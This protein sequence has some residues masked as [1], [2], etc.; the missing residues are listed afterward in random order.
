MP[1]VRRTELPDEL[2]DSLDDGVE[3]DPGEARVL[4]KGTDDDEVGTGA[5]ALTI[6]D[7]FADAST[8]YRPVAVHD[9]GVRQ[10]RLVAM[11]ASAMHLTIQVGSRVDEPVAL[12]RPS[13]QGVSHSCR[14]KRR[15][16]PADAWRS[17]GRLAHPTR[18]RHVRSVPPATESSIG[19]HSHVR[20]ER[21][22]AARSTAMRTNVVQRHTS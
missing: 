10:H 6:G 19:N 18:E 15:G 16:A 8:Q 20:A 9:N 5:A 14:A 11:F 3:E 12:A 1:G 2:L 7:A 13:I 22:T 4:T 21:P 17:P